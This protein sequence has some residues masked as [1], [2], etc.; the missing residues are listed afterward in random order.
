MF[1]LVRIEWLKIRKYRTFWVLLGLFF[2]C[3]PGITYLVYYFMTQLPREGRRFLDADQYFQFPDVWQTAAYLGSF[4]LILLGMLVITLTTN[5]FV[6]RTHRQ[7]IIDGWNRMQ[8]IKA[9]WV[10][11]FMF[12]LITAIC[13]I[14]TALTFGLVTTNHL[15]GPDVW[16]H[17]RIIWFCFLQALTY[18]S[19]AFLFGM[20]FRRAGLAIGLFF[21]YAFILEKVAAVLI[22]HYIG[23]YGKFLPLESTN[24]LIPNP[25]LHRIPGLTPDPTNPYVYFFLGLGYTALFAFITV[26]QMTRRDL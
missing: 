5:E 13:L 24:H 17:V 2:L 25:L 7:N 4:A 26:R 8:F 19:V 3:F 12:S 18:L 16:E 23:P 1:H 10:L 14:L 6:F 20:L 21:L 9:K 11:L 15:Y 22:D